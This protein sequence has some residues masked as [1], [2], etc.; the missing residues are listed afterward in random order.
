MERSQQLCR[1]CENGNW[2]LKLE[3]GQ[4]HASPL[5][6]FINDNFFNILKSKV[7]INGGC[8]VILKLYFI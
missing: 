8:I 6:L 1:I 2:T 4:V 5:F 7:G 3:C